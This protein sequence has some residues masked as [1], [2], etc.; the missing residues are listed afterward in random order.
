M[1]STSYRRLSAA[2]CLVGLLGVAGC[3][4]GP[5]QLA[6]AE[7]Q[8][9]DLIQRGVPPKDPAWDEVVSAFESIPKD[10][11]A[12]PKAELHLVALRALRGTLPL[13]PLVTPGG[14]GPGTS[15]VATQRG[16][17]EKLVR[18][19]GRAT[20]ERREKMR[21]ALQECREKLDRLEA[22]NHPPGEDGGH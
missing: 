14:I 22:A 12:R 1:D 5:E 2:L 11:S 20:E 13:R 19:M 3:D 4:K 15:A 21:E 9:T 17:C 16:E 10:S 8:Y 18:E 6:K 7:A